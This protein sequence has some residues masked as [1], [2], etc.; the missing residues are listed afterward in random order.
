MISS[1]KDY[2][3]GDLALAKYGPVTREN[4]LD[5]L[6]YITKLHDIERMVMMSSE[7]GQDGFH[8]TPRTLQVFE[9]LVDGKEPRA[10]SEELGYPRNKVYAYRKKFRDAGIL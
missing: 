4:L 3:Y 1:I 10:I 5:M 7:N 6:L 9:G 8:I 2:K